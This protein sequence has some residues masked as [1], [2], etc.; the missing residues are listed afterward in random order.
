[1][2]KRAFNKIAEGLFE[3]LA[4]A[5]GEQKPARLSNGG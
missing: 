5:R 3:A 2:S 4:V 1:M